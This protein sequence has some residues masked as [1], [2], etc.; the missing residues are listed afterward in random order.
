ML[1]FVQGWGKARGSRTSEFTVTTNENG[2]AEF[3]LLYFDTVRAKVDALPTGFR[4]N[5]TEYM[6]DGSKFTVECGGEEIL[7]GEDGR[8]SLTFTDTA[9]YQSATFKITALEDATEDI[10][11]DIKGS[12]D[13]PISTVAYK[14]G[15]RTETLT[16]LGA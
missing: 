14:G 12:F 3:E 13:D 8:I 9:P 1:P 2:L 4:A 11:I 5:T 10:D 7:A 15:S 16:F 6:F